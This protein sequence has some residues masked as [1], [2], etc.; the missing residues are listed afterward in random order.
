[1]VLEKKVRVL[2]LDPKETEK[3]RLVLQR[4]QSLP[5]VYVLPLTK[6]YFKGHTS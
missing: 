2:H 6:T 1:M 3:I 5:L 4:L